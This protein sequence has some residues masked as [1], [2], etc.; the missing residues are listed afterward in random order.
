MDLAVVDLDVAGV[1]LLV[2][3]QF[4]LQPAVLYLELGGARAVLRCGW[5]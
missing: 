4:V 5:S 2:E 3:S 1:R